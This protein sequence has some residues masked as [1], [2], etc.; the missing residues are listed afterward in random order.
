MDDFVLQ[1]LDYIKLFEVYMGVL[2]YVIGG[3]LV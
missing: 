1:L 3:V 2:D